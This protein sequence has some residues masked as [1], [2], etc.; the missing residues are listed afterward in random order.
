MTVRLPS[1]DPHV[2]ESDFSRCVIE[3]SR[4]GCHRSM[5]AVQIHIVNLRKEHHSAMHQLQMDAS[6]LSVTLA[7]R[8]A[9]ARAEIEKQN[10][11][12]RCVHC[13]CSPA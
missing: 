7:Q 9:E 1:G 5:E 12:L 2:W 6:S 11:R 3:M 4:D 8:M 13:A 10:Q